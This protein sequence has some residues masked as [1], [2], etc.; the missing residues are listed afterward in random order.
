M[1]DFGASL[2]YSLCYGES[3]RSKP[4]EYVSDPKFKNCL[5]ALLAGWEIQRYEEKNL[6]IFFKNGYSNFCRVNGQLIGQT[7]DSLNDIEYL[8]I[9]W[10]NE[11]ANRLLDP[12]ISVLMFANR[13]LVPFAIEML[14]ESLKNKLHVFNIENINEKEDDEILNFFLDHN[15]NLVPELDM[16]AMLSAISTKAKELHEAGQRVR[17]ISSQTSANIDYKAM[18]QDLKKWIELISDNETEKQIIA[19]VIEEFDGTKQRSEET[20]ESNKAKK[21]ESESPKSDTAENPGRSFK[22]IIDDETTKGIVTQVIAA[23]DERK[24]QSK[25]TG[26]SN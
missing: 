7:F 8:D 26:E 18:R 12:D 15:V 14:F 22:L 19:E 9:V 6:D 3:N 23:L 24:Q 4:D 5:I 13:E 1:V 20:E 2:L 11:I 17:N 10:D 25:D 16:L 21:N